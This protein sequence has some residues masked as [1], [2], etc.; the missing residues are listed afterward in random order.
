MGKRVKLSEAAKYYITGSTAVDMTVEDIIRN[1]PKAIV[2]GGRATN[3]YLPSYL[4]KYTEDWDVFVPSNARAMALKIEQALD[5]RYDG[6]FFEV[7]P[8]LHT[9]TFRVM[10]KVTGRPVAD[11]SIPERSIPFKRLMDGINY[12]TLDYHVSQIKLTFTLSEKKFR[13]PKDSET[14]QRIEV[15]K[16]SQVNEFL[17]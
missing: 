10:N 9:G 7:K 12:A 3:A 17:I 8:A 1:T 11:I 15:Y 5:E 14:L 4:D 6:N 2:H 13:W 16:A